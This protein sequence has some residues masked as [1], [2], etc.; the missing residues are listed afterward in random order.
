MT[1][2]LMSSLL[3]G[4]WAL[5]S[6]SKDNAY[7][8]SQNGQTCD[9]AMISYAQSIATIMNAQCNSC[10]SGSNPDGNLRTNS[11]QELSAINRDRL[12]G[13]IEHASGYKPMPDGAPKMS[14]CDINKIKAWIHQGKLNN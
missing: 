13:A 4:V 2:F 14:D 12:V 5:S 1:K 6:C 11:H 8:L 10:H 9:T 7:T 3:L